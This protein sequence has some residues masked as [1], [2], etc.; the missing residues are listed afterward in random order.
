M[1]QVLKQ[2]KTHNRRFAPL[3]NGVEKPG[4]SPVIYPEDLVGSQFDWATLVREGR[5]KDD[6][7]P[8]LVA[9]VLAV[10][11][12]EAVILDAPEDRPPQPRRR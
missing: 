7:A 2:F 10:P 1:A 9:P 11:V 5:I 6:E 4:W 8:V 3:E 12:S